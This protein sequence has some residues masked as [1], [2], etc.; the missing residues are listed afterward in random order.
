MRWPLLLLIAFPLAS[1]LAASRG[2][3]VGAT[4]ALGLLVLPGVL[5]AIRAGGT[6]RGWF[7]FLALLFLGLGAW[8]GMALA[9]LFYVPVI[10]PLGLMLLFAASLI[11]GRR[12]WV[13]RIASQLEG[14]LSPK[15]IRYT[16]AVTLVWVV[17]FAL[18]GFSA[19]YLAL[20]ATVEL[21]SLFTNGLNYLL[22][23][24]VFIAEFM[25]RRRVLQGEANPDFGAFL[26]GMGQI[27]AGSRP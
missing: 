16:R 6:V 8:S 26:R 20:F 24:F 9:W 14:P 22:I 23:A 13:T 27:R 7:A 5:G 11:P 3:A 17:V 12:P 18:L 15:A 19:L 25:V 4:L 21:W 10:L 1:H 2:S